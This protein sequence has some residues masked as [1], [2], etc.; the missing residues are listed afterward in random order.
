V[1]V[2]D[3][4]LLLP[5]RQRWRIRD[6]RAVADGISGQLR[7]IDARRDEL[8]AMWSAGEISRKEWLTARHQL[9]ASADALTAELPRTQHGRALAQFAA[10]TGTVW[11]C[12][13]QMTTGAR[14]ALIQSVT[15]AIP[16]HPATT[17]R[18]NPDRIGDPV[19][20]A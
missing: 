20:R 8:A 5:E 19:W 4:H 11:D 10:M 9:S 13:E 18:W 12:W 1:S 2:T 17:R 3:V 16:V 14:R 15:A 7:A 6:I